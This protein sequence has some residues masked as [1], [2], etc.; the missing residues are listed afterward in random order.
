MQLRLLTL[1]VWGFPT[2]VS[3]I[4]DARMRAIGERLP[5]FA[6]DAAAFQE[7]WTPSGRTELV[8]AGQRA[9]LEHSWYRDDLTSNSGLL[10]LSRWPM[11]EIRF[12]PF[13]LCG[14]PQ[15]LTHLD[16]YGG[17]GFVSAV[18]DTPEGE[19]QLL[20]THLHAAYG[21]VGFGDEYLG[22]RMAEIIE[23]ALAVALSKRPVALLGDLNAYPYRDELNVLRHTTGLKDVAR[24]VQREQ[25]TILPR[26]PFRPKENA[27]GPRID[28]VLARSGTQLGLAPVDAQRVFEENFEHEGQTVTYSDHAGVLGVLELGGR[29]QPLPAPDPVN[30]ARA[31]RT[32]DYGKRIATA[33]R[34]GQ[35][36]VAAGGA[37]L[38]LA[39]AAASRSRRGVLRTLALGL[40]GALLAPSAGILALGELFTP[41]E[42]QG[43]RSVTKTLARLEALEDGR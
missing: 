32:L 10:I 12:E 24:A 39:T 23:I 5:E 30:I 9:G 43:Y 1:N 19:L 25:A 17:K 36:A 26:S 14:L 40:T 38:G 33:R 41:A 6:L 2:P 21:T 18:L 15:R 42:L 20:N 11:R 13:T 31:R 37:A 35:R 3:R 34:R 8:A 28:Y 16:Y 27:P 29:G 7:V 4:P 22:H